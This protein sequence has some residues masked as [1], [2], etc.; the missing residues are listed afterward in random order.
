[1][2]IVCNEKL[3]FQQKLVFYCGEKRR[4]PP[5]KSC[6]KQHTTRYQKL[7]SYR[8]QERDIKIKKKIERIGQNN[9]NTLIKEKKN[10]WKCN[11][12]ENKLAPLWFGYTHS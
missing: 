2:T 10:G 3:L 11:R 8:A 6:Q 1:M 5:K 7:V 12:T 4:F 9:Y